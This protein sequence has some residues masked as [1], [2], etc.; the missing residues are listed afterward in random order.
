MIKWSFIIS[1]ISFGVLLIPD[2]KPPYT[3]FENVIILLGYIGGFG[4]WFMI[5]TAVLN[6]LINISFRTR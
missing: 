2:W 5:L 6:R 3:Y 1:A 4:P